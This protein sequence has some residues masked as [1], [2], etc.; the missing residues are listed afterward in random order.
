MSIAGVAAQEIRVPL[1]TG[2]LHNGR[3]MGN[4]RKTYWSSRSEF[5]KACFQVCSDEWPLLCRKWSIS[6]VQLAPS[7]YS[8]K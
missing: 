2:F 7:S 3:A 1:K 5:K 4:M 8:P 6:K